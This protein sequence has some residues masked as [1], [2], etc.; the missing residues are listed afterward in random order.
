[1]KGYGHHLSK[2]SGLERVVASSVEVSVRFMAPRVSSCIAVGFA[3]LQNSSD[4]FILVVWLHANGKNALKIQMSSFCSKVALNVLKGIH[5]A[6][7]NNMNNKFS[8][9]ARSAV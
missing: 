2:E 8:L 1:L 5:A 6:L 7:C 9:K 3:P 4:Q